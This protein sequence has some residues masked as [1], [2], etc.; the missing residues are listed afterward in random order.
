M[1]DHDATIELPIT[2]MTCA[3]CVARTERAIAKV[4]ELEFDA[5]L[6]VPEVRAGT[7]PPQRLGIDAPDA[8][9]VRVRTSRQVALPALNRAGRRDAA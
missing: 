6:H 4:E 7:L 5:V 9:T 3:S 1:R 8:R 2:G